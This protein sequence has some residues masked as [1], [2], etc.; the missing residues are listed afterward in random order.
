[1]VEDLDVLG[2][3]VPVGYSFLKM[4]PPT[5]RRMNP[6]TVINPGLGPVGRP[7]AV[8]ITHPHPLG[9]LIPAK[10]AGPRGARMR[11]A[12]AG[13]DVQRSSRVIGADMPHLMIYR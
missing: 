9:P 5:R 13:G 4:I 1:M 10:G 3:D 6:A 12:T 8:V 11:V 2:G 7:D